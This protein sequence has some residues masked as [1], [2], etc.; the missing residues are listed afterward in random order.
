M[1]I[2]LLTL[3][4]LLS[5]CLPLE[6]YDI[7]GAR[8]FEH[9][10]VNG[11]YFMEQLGPSNK[12]KEIKIIANESYA[13]GPKNIKYRIELQSH[14]YDI[15][16]QFPY[17]RDRIYLL[18]SEGKRVRSIGSG[19]WSLFLTLDSKEGKEL[20]EFTAKVWSFNYNPILHGPPN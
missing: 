17:I 11:S 19:T 7:T 2:T 5:G 1:P 4:F 15:A 18:N 8:E 9:L 3:L 14:D 12:A 16:E 6:Q 13:I 20:R 10:S